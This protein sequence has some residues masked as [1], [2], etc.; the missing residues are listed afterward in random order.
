MRIAVVG[1]GAIGGFVAGALAKAGNDVAVIARGEHLDAIR[2]HGLRIRSVLL[3]EFTTHPTATDDL[4]ECSNL[5]VVFVAIKAHQWDPVLEQFT[6]FVG[7][8]TAIVTLQNGLP[9]WNDP[10][11]S[12][13]CVDPGGRILKTFDYAQLVGGV[14]HAS[15]NIAAP[16]EVEHLGQARYI[17][18]DAA[19]GA[20]PR[21]ERIAQAMRDAGLEAPLEMQIR[22]AV[23]R[24]LFGNV[25]LNPMSALTRTTVHTMTHDARTRAL[26]VAM[27]EEARAVASAS[28]VDV[29]ETVAER[30]KH[31]DTLADVKTSMLQDLEAGRPLELEPIV[32]AVVELADRFGVAVPRIASVY[33]LAKLL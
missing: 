8:Q 3:G 17:L 19:G 6:P 4:R 15:G 2:S 10:N 21:T 14:V 9:F 16:G 18:G 27:I 5:D 22:R 32:G 33:A 11:R 23:W 26:M 29:Q 20:S 31:I 24:K 25:V 28:G 7:T 1:A 12:L 13:E 30:M